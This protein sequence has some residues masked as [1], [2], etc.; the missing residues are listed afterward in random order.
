MVKDG[1]NGSVIMYQYGTLLDFLHIG[2]SS[3]I[4]HTGWMGL[5]VRCKQSCLDPDELPTMNEVFPLIE[6]CE[7]T[8]EAD[9]RILDA[10]SKIN[11]S[12]SGIW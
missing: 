4:D 1:Y 8:S 9:I 2:Q 12:C 7:R 3:S 5:I 6:K 11:H 10:F